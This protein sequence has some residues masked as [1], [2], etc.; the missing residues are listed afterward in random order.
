[1]KRCFAAFVMSFAF[2]SANA[3]SVS[4]SDFADG[5]IGGVVGG[6]IK[7]PLVQRER[8]PAVRRTVRRVIGSG[9]E[10]N[11]TLQYD[12]NS[13]GFSVGVVDGVLGRRSREEIIAFQTSI[14]QIPTG[15]LTFLERE[16]LRASAEMMR[17]EPELDRQSVSLMAFHAASRYQSQQFPTSNPTPRPASGSAPIASRAFTAP[18]GNPP[19]GYRGYGIVA[20]KSTATE[21]DRKRHTLICEAYSASFLE[22][23][24]VG[25]EITDQFITVWPVDDAN[26]FMK[27]QN[28]S[29]ADATCE[30]AIKRYDIAKANEAIRAANEA[31]FDD[32]GVG[33]FLLG[34]LPATKFGQKDALILSL[35]L[36]NVRTYEQALALMQ[37]WRNDIENDPALRN[38]TMS[39]DGIRRKIR[40]W[41]DQHGQGIFS[42]FMGG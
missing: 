18:A 41:S 38:G 10:S 7:N 34:W 27:P 32:Q 19:K 29:I 4:N 3:Q 20:F 36:S 25:S 30:S 11:R 37:D 21:Y 26:Q 40:R 28:S 9:R 13:L 8:R 14:G 22:R 5:M 6:I 35:D 2:T 39:L 16:A 24:V 1:M 33:P 31:G 42:M 23:E 17:M 12:L 15:Y